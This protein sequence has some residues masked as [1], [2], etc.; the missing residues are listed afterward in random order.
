MKKFAC[1]TL[2]LALAASLAAPAFAAD[3]NEGIMLISAP[4]TYGYEITV[5]GVKLDTSKLPIADENY[6]PMRAVAEGDHGNAYW[7]EDENSGSFNMGSLRVSVS[8]ADNTITVGEDKLDAA[9]IVKNGVTFVPVSVF[10]GEEG[11]TATNKDGKIDIVTPNNAPLAKLG[12]N[13]SDAV[14]LYAPRNPEDQ[15][16]SF[17]GLKAE[18]YSEFASFLPM[19][20]VKSTSLFIAKVA[21]GKLEAAKTELQTYHDSL[22]RNFEHYLVDQYELAQKGKIVTEGKYIMFVV[23]EDNDKAIEMFKAFVAEQ[24]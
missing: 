11:Y 2:S 18:N 5:N 20:N 21:D 24:K 9:A 14:E 17:F 12:Y 8:F 3:A 16:E 1:L 22:L 7:S 19:M 23:S 10:E 6:I 15:L 13:I 4:L